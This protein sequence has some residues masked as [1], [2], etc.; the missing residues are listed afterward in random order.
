M[1]ASL[2][3]LMIARG[4]VHAESSSNAKRFYLRRGYRI[5]GPQTAERRWPIT[6]ALR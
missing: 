4:V 2:E 3:A 5:S 6:K 1:L